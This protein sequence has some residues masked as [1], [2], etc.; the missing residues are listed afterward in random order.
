MNEG[1]GVDN[2][3]V[4]DARAAMEGALQFTL[5]FLISSW[6]EWV[7]LRLRWEKNLPLSDTERDAMLQINNGID[8]LNKLRSYGFD[9]FRAG[10]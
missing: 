2:R 10:E 3:N 9:R 1:E 6:Q 7:E 5:S 4:M 8:E